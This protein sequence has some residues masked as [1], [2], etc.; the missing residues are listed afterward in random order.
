VELAATGRQA[1]TALQGG[2]FDAIILNPTF[3]DATQT[4]L[5]ERE[6]QRNPDG[7]L[8]VLA[9]GLS[10][11]SAV[12]AARFHAAEYM[13]KDLSPERTA[14][15]VNTAL[16]RHTNKLRELSILRVIGD[17]LDALH[18]LEPGSVAPPPPAPAHLLHVPPLW[19]NRREQ[20]V[21]VGDDFEKAVHLTRSEVDVLTALMTHSG[22]VL[23]IAKLGEA[24]TGV[25]VQ[26]VA[27][28][29]SVAHIVHRLRQKVERDPA[30]P[31]LIR[32]IRGVGYV[33]QPEEAAK[34]GDWEEK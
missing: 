2:Q 10:T 33:L 24:A 3:L 14:Q 30:H 17:A 32:T 1:E 16:G 9:D 27:V 19:L 34:G 28:R 22:H 6:A 29:S 20:V 31:R 18:T 25:P 11:E 13:V 15:D 12:T 23:S 21:L 26:E 4:Q 7:L 5:L 8:L